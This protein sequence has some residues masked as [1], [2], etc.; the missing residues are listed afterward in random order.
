MIHD[1][2]RNTENQDSPSTAIPTVPWSTA[3]IRL[4][5][6]VVYSD[7]N[8]V[9]WDSLLRYT[10]PLT[11]YFAKI[12]LQLVVDESDGLAYLRQLD[13]DELMFNGEP[14]PKLYRRSPMGYET[15]LLCVL[16]RDLYRRFEEDELENE[17]C[18]I[19]HDE[20]LELWKPFFAKTS[21][22]VRLHRSLL[23]S[24]RKLEEIRFVRPHPSDTV[25]WEIRR[26]IK[27]RLPIS[28][29]ESL[30]SRIVAAATQGSTYVDHTTPAP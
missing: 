17:K 7:D 27:A 20:L 30:R 8:S 6:G 22:D 19:T 21:D 3:A 15:S 14:I 13:D 4:L 9:T 10:T 5:Q 18:V 12:G 29:L 2:L 24:L 26:I 1:S 25:S 11:D 28:E 16:L 23:S